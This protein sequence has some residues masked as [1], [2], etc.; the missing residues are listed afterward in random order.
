MATVGLLSLHLVSQPSK[1]H[2]ILFTV[3]GLHT[4]QPLWRGRAICQSL[5][6]PSGRQGLKSGGKVWRHHLCPMSYLPTPWIFPH[7]IY[8]FYCFCLQ[9]PNVIH[10]SVGWANMN[11]LTTYS[12]PLFV[13]LNLYFL[14]CVN[15]KQWKPIII[16]CTISQAL[17]LRAMRPLEILF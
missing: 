1:Y 13:W 7:N 8:P 4:F 15:S 12:F 17:D 6:S 14:Q 11:C 16:D 5:F 9:N 2:G 3:L 10:A